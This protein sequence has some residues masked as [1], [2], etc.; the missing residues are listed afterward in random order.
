LAVTRPLASIRTSEIPAWVKGLPLA[1]SS[2]EGAYRLLAALFIAAVQD[3]LVATSRCSRVKLPEIHRPP[4]VPMERAEVEAI[5]VAFP[6]HLAA[7]MTLAAAAGMR[8][9]ELLG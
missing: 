3:R 4:V 9:G 2:A 8:Q 1:P 6:D 5:T 7:M